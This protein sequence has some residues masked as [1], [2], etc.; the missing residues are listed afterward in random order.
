[1]YI[2]YNILNGAEYA[3][4]RLSVRNGATVSHHKSITL[5]RVLDKQRMI[6]KSHEH[7]V[8]QY[9]I[10][11]GKRMPPPEDFDIK[12]VRKNAREI[13]IVDFGNVNFFQKYIERKNLRSV[14]DSVGYGNPD[15]FNSLL[16][17]YL[18]E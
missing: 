14:I 15:S 18:L 1:M 3:R 7:G 9:D 10:S 4:L 6:F 2:E 8:Y 17:Y 5:G 12:V 11:T 13:L 16:S